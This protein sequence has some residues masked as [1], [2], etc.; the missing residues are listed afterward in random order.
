[1]ADE[2]LLQALAASER[3]SMQ[4][5]PKEWDELAHGR[6]APDEAVARARDRA[7][8]TED[9]LVRARDL[10]TP[11]SP[12]FDD[13]LVDRLV[14]MAQA[15]AAARGDAPPVQKVNGAEVIHVSPSWWQRRR[16]IVAAGVM[17]AAAAVLVV[18]WPRAATDGTG[19]L[20]ALPHHDLWIEVDAQVRGSGTEVQKVAPGASI[21][22]YL[23]PDRGYD[24]APSVAACVSKDGT[25]RLLSL[26]PITAKPGET[27]DVSAKLPDDLEPGR[28]EL[29][30]LIA[31][32]PMRTDVP[33]LCAEPPADVRVEREPIEIVSR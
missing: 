29:V 5:R 18:A 13:A 24:V 27:F 31:G 12:E 2:D 30:T 9:D 19:N 33:S 20:V 16:A 8:A 6:L 10:F 3:E 23:R 22:V 4:A 25:T 11:P 1:M 26:S 28:W 14:A 32:G 7:P 21:R 17:A 15:S